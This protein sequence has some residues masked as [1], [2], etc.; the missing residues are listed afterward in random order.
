MLGIK[1]DLK[2]GRSG[3]G[4]SEQGQTGAAGASKVDQNEVKKKKR[5]VERNTGGPSATQ[6]SPRYLQSERHGK[7]LLGTDVASVA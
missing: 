2:E 1:M 3:V 5:K 4:R 6:L 7:R